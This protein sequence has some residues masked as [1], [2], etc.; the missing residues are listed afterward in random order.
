MVSRELA[1]R[2]NGEHSLVVLGPPAQ[3][4]PPDIVVEGEGD[5]DCRPNVAHVVRSPDKS[6]NQKDGNVEVVENLILL[7]KEVEGNGQDSP[8]EETIQETVV[9]GSGTEHLL[10]A[11]STPKDGSGEERVVSRASEVI[12]LLG[13]TDVG[14]PGHLVVENGRADEGRD[15][16][17]PHLAVEGDPRG[18]VH[19]VGEFEILCEMK[20]VRG[21]DVSVRLEVV[22]SGGV[23]GE[24]E[25]TEK[26]SNDVQ[27]NLDV[28]DGHDD[29]AR[30]TEDRG[31]ENC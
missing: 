16:S 3:I 30:N 24:P 23:A 20:S 29:T 10:G 27:G 28:R 31:E 1:T 12:L 19:V 4:I 11:E 5:G 7:A 18:D 13:Q 6:T 8:D 26:L 14:D 9:D 2:R 21:G 25:T 22:H 15:E 17:R